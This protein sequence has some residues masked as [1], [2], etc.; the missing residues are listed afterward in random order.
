[1]S[2]TSLPSSTLWH[3]L[4]DI[5]WVEHFPINIFS[6]FTNNPQV[7]LLHSEKHRGRRSLKTLTR[8]TWSILASS[9]CT[10]QGTSRLSIYRTHHVSCSNASA[11]FVSNISR[12]SV[13]ILMLLKRLTCFLFSFNVS[14]SV[15][16][17]YV[18]FF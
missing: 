16:K 17:L 9:K 12:I 10:P 6:Q 15:M 3:I 11:M 13:N 4:F 18:H 5:K 2:I 1:M 8:L 14:G 7:K